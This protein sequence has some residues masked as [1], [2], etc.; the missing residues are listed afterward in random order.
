MSRSTVRDG[1]RGGDRCGITTRGRTAEALERHA[2]A[3]SEDR[4][5]GQRAD[6]AAED[7]EDTVERSAAR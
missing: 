7:G 4:N 2:R 1:R 6:R 5:E 3:E